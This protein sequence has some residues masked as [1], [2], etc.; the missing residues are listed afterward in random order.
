M[1]EPIFDKA[2]RFMGGHSQPV[3]QLHVRPTVAGLEADFGVVD[4]FRKDYLKGD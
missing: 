2:C 3:E 1:L 4:N